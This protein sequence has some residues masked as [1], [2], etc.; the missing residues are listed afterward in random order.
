MTVT[1][2]FLDD[3]A[4]EADREY[5]SWKKRNP[6]VDPVTHPVADGLWRLKHCCWGLRSALVSK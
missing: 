2:E 6:G 1:I 3:L 5:E 4:K